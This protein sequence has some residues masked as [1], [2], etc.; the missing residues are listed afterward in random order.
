MTK[1]ISKEALF[2]LY[3]RLYFWEIELRDKI[4]ARIPVLLVIVLSIASLQS[5][6]I[7]K[8][9]PWEN[10]ISNLIPC[11]TLALSVI[12]LI[13]SVSYLVRSWHGME[14]F[15][16]PSAEKIENRRS[17]LMK[18]YVEEKLGD[19]K[20][21]WVAEQIGADLFDYYIE[22]SSKNSENNKLKSLRIYVATNWLIGAMAAGLTTFLFL[23]VKEGMC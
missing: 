5:F 11:V 3:E 7:D 14:Y 10:V 18:H 8:L 16:L 2:D 13:F 22:S 19:N 21:T 15:L 1:Q 20:D 9:L 23:K 12:A 6:L 17:I 4:S